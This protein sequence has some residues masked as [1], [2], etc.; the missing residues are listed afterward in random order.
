MPQAFSSS[1]REKHTV[2]VHRTGTICVYH[3]TCTRSTSSSPPHPLVYSYFQ[4]GKQINREIRP[5]GGN[6]CCCC[7]RASVT[8]SAINTAQ[9]L[10]LAAGCTT[11]Y[12]RV[13][14]YILELLTLLGSHTSKVRTDEHIRLSRKMMPALCSSIR[15]FGEHSYSYLVQRG[16][17]MRQPH[18]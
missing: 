4:D 17:R 6:C 2:R 15:L 8:C 9:T 7:C 1:Q 14:I 11:I 5:Q 16:D 12:T 3:T 13:H 10:Q 18:G